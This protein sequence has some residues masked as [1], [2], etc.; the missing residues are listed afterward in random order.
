MTE[1]RERISVVSCTG[2]IRNIEDLQNA[3]IGVNFVIH[4]AAAVDFRMFPDIKFLEHVNVLGISFYTVF[5]TI[6][7]VIIYIVL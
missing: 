3:I 7:L 4:A 5:K 6:Y 1:Y 2:D